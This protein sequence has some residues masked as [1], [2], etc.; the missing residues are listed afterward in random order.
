M[1]QLY[2]RVKI[3]FL[4]QVSTVGLDSAGAYEKHI[5]D[6]TRRVTFCDKLQ[7]LPFSVCKVFV[8]FGPGFSFAG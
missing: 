2:G 4:H 1:D 8:P 3:E 7:Y 6:L 5:G